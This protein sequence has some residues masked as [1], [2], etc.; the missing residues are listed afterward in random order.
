MRPNFF[1]R[2]D[3]L[4]SFM[5]ADCLGDFVVCIFN[6]IT[7]NMYFDTKRKVIEYRVVSAQA[8]ML[9]TTS[10]SVI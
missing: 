2:G 5:R 8:D 3:C 6:G 7:R 9:A 4:P 10:P 1:A